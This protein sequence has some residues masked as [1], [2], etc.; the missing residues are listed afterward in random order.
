MPFPLAISDNGGMAECQV[1]LTKGK[2]RRRLTGSSTGLCT[3]AIH[4]A[5]T[6]ISINM[7]LLRA[8]LHPT[9]PRT[10]LYSRYTDLTVALEYIDSP[11][12]GSSGGVCVAL[13]LAML[14]GDSKLKGEDLTLTGAID[15]RGRIGAVGGVEEKVRHAMAN[16][17]NLLVV[18]ALNKKGLKLEGKEEQEYLEKSVR[19]VNTFVDLLE[20]TIEGE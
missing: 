18:P 9:N 1:L 16:G 15:L 6:F 11:K 4:T 19:W 10:S 13:S 5:I 14:V 7:P 3:E 20:A 8:W 2:G 17:V 12:S